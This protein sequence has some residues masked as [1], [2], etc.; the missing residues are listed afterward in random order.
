M[1]DNVWSREMK[2]IFQDEGV[3]YQLVPSHIH[4][5]NVAE[6]DIRTYTNH[7]ISVLYTCDPKILSRELDRKLLPCNLTNNLLRSAR[8]NPTLSAYAT[9]MGNYDFNA[10]PMAPLVTKVIIHEKPNNRKTWVEHST[11]T[12]HIGPSLNY[13]RCIKFYMSDTCSEQNADTV[14]FSQ[15]QHHFQK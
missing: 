13:Y 3:K 11:D 6:R 12:W 2:L 10:T 4:H 7:L 1:L 14:E 8:R 15:W 9:L 5:R